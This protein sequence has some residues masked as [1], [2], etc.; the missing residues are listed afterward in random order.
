MAA[1]RLIAQLTTLDPVQREL[2]PL[3][4]GLE[5]CAGSNQMVMTVRVSNVVACGV[6]LHL[7]GVAL[8][9]DSYP[10]PI[11]LSLHCPSLQVLHFQPCRGFAGPP[12]NTFQSLPVFS[13]PPQLA[14]YLACTSTA[15]TLKYQQRKSLHLYPDLHNGMNFYRTIQFL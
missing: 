14:I 10:S 8:C 1:W 15:T 6:C 11:R 12:T 7:Q 13:F 3:W 9:Q 2:S 5:G 4:G